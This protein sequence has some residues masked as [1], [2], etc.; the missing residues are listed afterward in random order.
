MEYQFQ[1]GPEE[2][3]LKATLHE[4]E[5]SIEVAQATKRIPY[6]SVTEVRLGR[7]REAYFAEII[8]LDYGTLYLSS[9]TFKGENWVDQSRSYYTFMRVLHLHLSNKSKASFYSGTNLGQQAV[10]LLVLLVST[11]LLFLGE[12]YFDWIP[13]STLA[14]TSIFFV[15]GL[16]IIIIPSISHW[17]KSYAPTEIPM[18]LLPPA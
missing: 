6:T 17:P 2:K 16:S 18:E 1:N 7:R 12:A 4:F 13:F 11:A 3:L 5:I 14:V 8:S 15:A 10:K 9:K